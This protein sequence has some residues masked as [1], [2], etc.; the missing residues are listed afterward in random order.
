MCL[1]SELLGPLT[2]A[3]LKRSLPINY[4]GGA[5]GSVCPAVVTKR[6]TKL[7]TKKVTKQVA[8]R[9]WPDYSTSQNKDWLAIGKNTLLRLLSTGAESKYSE[10]VEIY[11]RNDFQPAHQRRK[12]CSKLVQPISALRRLSGDNDT[13]LAETPGF[14]CNLI[15]SGRS[16][17]KS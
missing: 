15:F 8:G 12:G 10:P 9:L 5:I 11:A 2:S 14:I 4:V 17:W 7:V 3:V 13:E 16:I 1:Q 6:V